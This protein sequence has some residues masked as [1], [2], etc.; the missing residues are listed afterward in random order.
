MPFL[1][2]C[3]LPDVVW[4]VVSRDGHP[5]DSL[6]PSI[7]CRSDWLL[8]IVLRRVVSTLDASGDFSLPSPGGEADLIKLELNFEGFDSSQEARGKKNSVTR[9]SALRSPHFYA[10]HGRRR[11]VKT[12]SGGAG[13]RAG[14]D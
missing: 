1:F 12:N 10:S 8:K 6:I 14:T 13:A 3:T 9:H 2:C 7:F 4:F 11:R 5:S